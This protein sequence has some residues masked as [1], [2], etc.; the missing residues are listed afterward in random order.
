METY[1]TE[2]NDS[3]ESIRSAASGSSEVDLDVIIKSQLFEDP[4]CHMSYKSNIRLP[5][6]HIR[7]EREKLRW[8]KT[9]LGAILMSAK[10]YETLLPAGWRDWSGL[11]GDAVTAYLE[12][13]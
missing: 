5:H 3:L 7:V 1:R 6:S 11:A 12:E 2:G 13:C 9:I 10:R 8:W 4:D